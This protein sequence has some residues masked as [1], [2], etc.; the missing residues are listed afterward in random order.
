LPVVGVQALAKGLAIVA[1][2]VGGFVDL[3]EEGRNGYLVEPRDSAGF[4]AKLHHLLTNPGHLLS[5]R[6]FSLEQAGRF[7]IEHIAGQYETVFQAILREGGGNM[8]S[9]GKK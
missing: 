2:C 7:E 8:H 9:K 5:L 4:A 6:K 1:S 3:V